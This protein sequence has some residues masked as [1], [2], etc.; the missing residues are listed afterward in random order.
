[1][2]NRACEKEIDRLLDRR[3]ARRSGP[4]YKPVSLG[5]LVEGTQSLLR[6]KLTEPIEISNP[7][8]LSG[9]TSKLQMSF[10]LNWEKPFHGRLTERMVLRMEPAESL[11]E[12]SRRR[13]FELVEKLQGYLPLPVAHWVDPDGVHFP[14]PALI[15]S[16]VEGV[17]SPS[18]AQERVSGMGLNFGPHLRPVLAEQF[19]RH[20]AT[21]HTIDPASLNLESFDLPNSSL[22]AAEWQ[23]N[24]WERIWREDYVSDS[25]VV[26]VAINWLRDNLPAGDKLSIVHGDFR[27]GNFLFRESDGQIT[28]WLDWE[29]AHIGD[30]HE[31][32]AYLL[33]HA[34]G[35]YAEDGSTYLV[36]GLTDR[37]DFLE[38]Y[39]R[40]T[41]LAVV[42]ETLKFYEVLNLFK[43]AAITRAT[44]P[45][46]LMGGK[47]HQDTVVAYAHGISYLLMEELRRTLE[48]VI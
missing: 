23:I 18:D 10:D 4:P 37:E 36:C 41:G 14:Y 9:G 7:R 12:T 22:Q 5:E 17:A 6:T 47:C 26:H 34:Y 16:M 28:A 2:Q 13:E 46:I 40:E 21:L 29:L 31:D 32:L 11:V 25:P 38:R 8:W 43:C 3:M 27:N 15:Y 19:I 35:H 24:W 45:R 20:L 30:R 42:P 1:M 48:E 39:E 44:S 33:Q